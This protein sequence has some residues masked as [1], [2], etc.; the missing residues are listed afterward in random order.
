MN[1]SS[2]Q[3]PPRPTRRARGTAT[4]VTAF[5]LFAGTA[6]AAPPPATTTPADP[7][8]PPGPTPIG[9]TTPA[10][11]PK[12]EDPIVPPPEPAPTSTRP[13]SDD[14]LSEADTLVVRAG[15][16]ID[17]AEAGPSGP[18]IVS[19]MEEL[20]NL[21]LRRAEILP[22]RLGTDPVIR[23]RVSLQ[24][25]ASDVFVIK[26]DVTLR[27]EP[28]DGSS[29]EVSCS[30]CTEGEVVERARGEIVRL[31][32]FVR[33]RFRPAEK[34]GPDTSP[35]PNTDT[36][37]GPKPLTNLGKAGIGLLAGGTLAAAAGLGLALSKPRTDP[38]DPTREINTRPAGFG[39]LAV[40][41]AA[42]VTGAILLALDRRK[43]N[44]R[45][46]QVVPTGGP[47]SAG[48]LLFGRF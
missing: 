37:T 23:I 27:G 12:P 39:V 32:P 13:S 36:N 34:K 47:S 29:R 28:M 33:A 15:L 10:D 44:S 1:T 24:P 5:Y 14:P 4:L 3:L 31:V 21:E 26:S 18:V 45:S 2:M 42:L 7:S 16:D 22:S 6:S 40:G 8:T 20:G 41:G 35:K 43:A 46:V 9:P 38:D 19:R 11:D 48:L 17:T 30:L 25:G